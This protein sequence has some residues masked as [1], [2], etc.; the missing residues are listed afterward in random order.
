[1]KIKFILLFIAITN[2][3]SI[4]QKYDYS[5]ILGSKYYND[6]DSCFYG[7]ELDF[8]N[9]LN[10]HRRVLNETINAHNNSFSDFNG[11][12][13]MYTNGCAFFNSDDKIME[14]GDSLNLTYD[15]NSFCNSDPEQFG[16][17]YP[18]ASL[19][20][21]V[22]DKNIMYLSLET[23]TDPNKLPHVFSP[24]ILASL[25]NIREKKVLYKNK[26]LLPDSFKLNRHG[27]VA[28]KHNDNISWWVIS[29]SANNSLFHILKITGDSVSYQE[30]I[31][32]ELYISKDLG[33]ATFNSSGNILAWYSRTNGLEIMNFDRTTGTLSEYKKISIVD[34][35]GGYGGVAFSPNERFLY[36]STAWD[37]YQIDMNAKDIEQ[38]M[39]L[40]QHY[41]GSYCNCGSINFQA[42]YYQMQL[43]PDCRIYIS[44]HSSVL[45]LHVILYPD[46]K[47]KECQFVETGL[48]LSSYN[49]RSI[50]EFPNYRIEKTFPCDSTLRT[51]TFNLKFGD[52]YQ[53]ISVYPNLIYDKLNLDI[54][55]IGE[56]YANFELFTINGK[57]IINDKLS[58]SISHYLYDIHD[59]A[60]GIYFYQIFNKKGIL[61]R[62]RLVKPE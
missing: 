21:P 32:G 6:G 7:I 40:I 10:I 42:L 2:L 48:K 38:S 39:E 19:F 52:E 56:N 3:Y 49:Y 58:T 26:P 16:I 17:P 37:L 43:G 30:Q 36:V 33:Q 12:L 8:N 13:L 1:M 29:R 23:K 22:D 60:P 51:E 44:S 47:A 25:I 35:S 54:E 9:R 20:L 24:N 61:D 4:A 41:N 34:S 53:L 28:C 45:C 62:G 57:R 50:P 11:N 55:L 31:I 5:W 46:R 59:L 15:Y 18:N 27:L 14:N